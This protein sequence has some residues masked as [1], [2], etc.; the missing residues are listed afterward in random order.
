MLYSAKFQIF[1]TRRYEEEQVAG[2]GTF[3]FSLHPIRKHQ[4]LSKLK[5]EASIFSLFF[6]PNQFAKSVLQNYKA[7]MI[8][9]KFLTIL[10]DRHTNQSNVGLAFH[11]IYLHY[12]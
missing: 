3:N 10:L 12:T 4:S 1:T 6:P 5:L 7:L 2:V 9:G 8:C 11:P